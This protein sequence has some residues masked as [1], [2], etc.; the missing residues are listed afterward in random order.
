MRA[1]QMSWP[2]GSS[3]LD[4]FFAQ[5]VDGIQEHNEVW[6]V[7]RNQTER[8]YV[9]DALTIRGVPLTNIIFMFE[10][11]DAFWSRDYGPIY[12]RT[13]TGEASI[14]DPMYYWTRAHDDVIPY[15]IGMR[16]EIAVHEAH[17]SFEGGNFQSDGHGHCFFLDGI[18][19]DNSN[20]T[21]EEIHQIFY[22]YFGC[23]EIT[24][25]QR[26]TGGVI[27][28]IDMFA[29][30]I[31]PTK[32]LVGQYPEGDPNYQILEDNATLLSSLMAHNGEPFEVVRIPMPPTT[33]TTLTI[34]YSQT[35]PRYDETKMDSTILQDEVW[36]THTNSTIADQIVLVPIFEHGTD[37]EALQI[38]RDEMP[39]YTIVGI[40]S[41]AIIPLQ[42]AMHCVT[43]EI[44]EYAPWEGLAF[45]SIQNLSEVVGNGNS[46]IDPGETWEFQVV[47]EN[48]GTSAAASPSAR[49]TLHSSS[50]PAVTMLKD[51]A[52]YGDIPSGDTGAS[53]TTYVLSLDESYSCAEPIVLNLVDTESSLGTNPDQLQCMSLNVGDE[54][55][56]TRFWDDMEF[57]PGGWTHGPIG[58]A[59]DLWHQQVD[60]GCFPAASPTTQWVFVE[61]SDCNYSTGSIVAGHLTS[62]TIPVSSDSRLYFDYFRET[63][64][65]AYRLELFAED[66]FRIEVSDDAFSTSEIL[67]EF[68][69]MQPS[70]ARWLSD[71]PYDLSSYSGSSI[72]VR[73]TFDSDT[74]SGNLYR[75]IGIDD[76]LVE[77]RTYSCENYG[78][79]LP[80]EVPNGLNAPGEMLMISKSGTDLVINWDIGCNAT[81]STDYAIYRGNISTLTSGSWDHTP[82]TCTDAGADLTETIAPDAGSYYY[83]V[84]PHD[85]IVEGNCGAG[86]PGAR[87]NSSS[88]C[89]PPGG[90]SCL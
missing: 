13:P 35:L 54:T 52:N 75:G 33:P 77:D 47:L 44:P 71:G 61:D 37:E 25:L 50:S 1:Q 81:Y 87:P 85:G 79:P 27:E 21:Q 8:D 30:L 2:I 73:F 58:L 39:G 22:D 29:K 3:Y 40:N 83:I 17:L 88:A 31:S 55:V 57:G 46:A 64:P 89:Y 45:D 19:D 28:H 62:D 90:G 36:R 11:R 78:V 51:H 16:E 6:M 10:E 32:W 69:C 24:P 9:E 23:T 53:S 68:S 34:D 63:D 7:L 5:L 67:A 14:T 4:D 43:M 74:A 18:Y 49:V 42:G 12:L 76:V 59:L 38:Y 56:I 48:R 70:H 84:V 65:C 20:M 41:E 66:F 86:T 26:M 82:V 80:G 72:Q 15:R 60:P